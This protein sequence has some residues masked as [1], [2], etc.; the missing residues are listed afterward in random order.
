MATCPVQV[1]RP[2]RPQ[3]TTL[4]KVIQHNLETWLAARRAA[5]PEEDPI[6]AYVE[7]AFREYLSCGLHCFGFARCRCSSCGY[8]FLTAFSCQRKGLCPSCSATYMVRTA[9][10]LVD[11]VLPRVP[12]RQW[13]LALPK[14]L[15]YFLHRDAEHAGGVLRIFLRAVETTIRKACTD[16]PRTSRFGAVSFIHRAGSTFNQHLHYHCIVTEGVFAPSGCGEA[17]FFQATGIDDALIDGLAEKIRRR[18]LRYMVRRDLIDEQVAVDMDAWHH[19]AGFSLDASVRVERDDRMALERLVRYCARPMFAQSRLSMPEPHTVVY[20]LT[21][22]DP[23]GRLAVTFKPLEFLERI[24]ALI[25]PPRVHRHRYAGV[26]APNCPLRSRVVASAGPAE[27]LAT[28]LDEAAR[29]MNLDHSG[30]QEQPDNATTVPQDDEPPYSSR[31]SR[32]CWAMLLARIYDVLPL[33][34]PRCSHPMVILSFI[35]QPD[36][37]VR[38]LTHI[39]EPVVPPPLAPARDVQLH[40]LAPDRGRGPP[41]SSGRTVTSDPDW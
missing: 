41:D 2:R 12:Y 24:A 30:R 28:R 8:E 14:R 34:C 38:I 37:I 3:E 31:K 18:V 29:A 11:N 22:P 16:A 33:L 27:A 32:M 20:T 9:A 40:L 25:P 36:V 4:Y 17:R 39:D 5:D 23:H 7:Q 10:H 35:T 21:K 13:V 15:R 26:L 6:P 19:H 1:Y